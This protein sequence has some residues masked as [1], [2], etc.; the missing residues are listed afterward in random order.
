LGH[1]AL[2]THCQSGKSDVELFNTACNRHSLSPRACHRN[3]KVTRTLADMEKQE[4][5]QPAHLAKAISCRDGNLFK[6]IK[7]V[8][9]A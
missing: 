8:G 2:K 6:G 7:E 4:T 1:E 5:N 9:T 3:L